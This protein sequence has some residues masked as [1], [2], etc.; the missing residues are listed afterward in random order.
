MNKHLE[1]KPPSEKQIKSV[2]N[3]IKYFKQGKMVIIV[4]DEG[5]VSL[6]DNSAVEGG[7]ISKDIFSINITNGLVFEQG[8]GVILSNSGQ[9]FDGSSAL[10]QIFSLPQSLGTSDS[11]SFNSLTEF[12]SNRT[13]NN[14]YCRRKH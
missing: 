2:E 4:D 6:S 1:V 9:S 13:R 3:A 5:R 12:S 10:T 11:V 14:Y 7:S 8:T